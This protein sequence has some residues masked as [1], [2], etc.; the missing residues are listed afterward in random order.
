MVTGSGTN[1][2][3]LDYM[4]NGIPVVSTHVGARGLNIP[5]GY[6]VKCNLEEFPSYIENIDCYTDILKSRTF[7]EDSFSWKTIAGNCKH[8]LLSNF[9]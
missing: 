1:L 4:A 3:M 2:K 5:D 9:R 6:I 7:V 8:L